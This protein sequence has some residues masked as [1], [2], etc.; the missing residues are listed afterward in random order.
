MTARA[1]CCLALLTA[2]ACGTP[3]AAD[4]GTAEERG[5]R[6]LV[7]RGCPEC[8]RDPDSGAWSGRTEPLLG[9]QVYPSNL[10]PDPDAGIG[11]WS[12]DEIARA[13]RDGFS[14]G[15]VPLCGQ[16]ARFDR[17][18]D[19]EVLAIIAI[20]RAQPASPRRVPASHCPP[21]KQ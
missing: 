21:I 9:T 20:L 3:T 6:Y 14:P 7:R 8:H 4:A 10:T 12:D 15:L 19:D 5:E 16:M 18:S 1:S 13:I 17:M 2:A 11:G